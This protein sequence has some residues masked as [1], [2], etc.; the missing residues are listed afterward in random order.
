MSNGIPKL[1][2]GCLSAGWH[3]ASATFIATLLLSALSASGNGASSS[4]SYLGGE[5]FNGYGFTAGRYLTD[6]LAL[7]GTI[8][9]TE[10]FSIFQS[11]A[12]DDELIHQDEA[13]VIAGRA[14]L[15]NSFN[16]K[17]GMYYQALTLYCRLAPVDPIRAVGLQLSLGNRWLFDWFYFGVDWLGFGV[18][19]EIHTDERNTDTGRLLLPRLTVGLVF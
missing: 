9:K 16:V 3:A 6:R 15:G 19:R 17:A 7:E 11:C 18:G 2:S 10:P 12:P 14:F 13:V 8:E 1:L 4:S 5:I